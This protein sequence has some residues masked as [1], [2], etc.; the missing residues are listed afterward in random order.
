MC[1]LLGGRGWMAH[2][3]QMITLEQALKGGGEHAY[4]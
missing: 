2:V 4:W 3:L 1:V